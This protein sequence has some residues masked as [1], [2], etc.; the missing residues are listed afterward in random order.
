MASSGERYQRAQ[1]IVHALLE[2]PPAARPA[3]LA[4]ACGTD[5]AL[6]EEVQWLLAAAER[7]DDATLPQLQ[8]VEALRHDLGAAQVGSNAPRH[9]RLIERLGEGGM[10]QVWL[11]ERDD[12][13]VRQRVALKLL[14]TGAAP[15][16]GERARFMA[17]GRILAALNHPNIAH[18]VDAGVGDD[19]MPFLAMECVDGLALD[20]W[21]AQ[22]ELTL[23]GRIELFLKVCAAV[24]YAHA[25]LVIHRDLKP[26]NILV[27]AAGEPKLLDFG[28]ARLLDAEVGGN[29]TTVLNAMT[30]AYAS[31]EQIRGEPLGTATD[32]YSLGV[33]LYQLLTGVRPFDHLRTEHERANAIVSGQV[34]PPS[35][36]HRADGG[37]REPAAAPVPS[38]NIPADIDAIVLKALRR[39][40]EQRYTSVSELAQDLRLFLAARP[41]LARRGQWG[42]RARCFLRR[43]RWPLAMAMALAA[44]AGGFTWRTVLAE[45]EARAQARTAERVTAFLSSIF[46]ASDSNLNHSLHS[47]LTARDVLDAGT[48]RI[49][50]ELTGEPQVRAR[51][52]EAVGN[53]YRH[54]NAN[55]RA[56]GL[57]REA[58]ELNLSPAVDDRIAAARCLEALANLLA[59]GEFRASEAEDA[60][61][62]SLALAQQLTPAGSQAIANAWMVLSL[63]QNRA[64]NYRAAESSART[65]LAMNLALRDAPGQRL[66]AAYHNLCLILANRGELDEAVR[67]CELTLPVYA[68]EQQ[69]ESVGAAMTYSRSAQARARRFEVQPALAEID[70]ALRIARAAHGEQAPFAALFQLRKAVILD[71]LGHYH[72]A[73]GVLAQALAMQERINGRDSGEYAAVRLELARRQLL[74]GELDAALPVLGTLAAEFATRYGSDDPRTADAQVL[75]AQASIDAGEA[76]RAARAALD[77]ASRAW[78]GK[79]DPESPAALRVAATLAQWFALHGDGDPAQ[80]L[81]ARVLAPQA[82]S[83]VWARTRAALARA[84]LARLQGQP[85]AAAAALGAAYQRLHDQ[86]GAAHPVTARIGL[87]YAQALDAARQ[88]TL[89]APL[90]EQLQAIVARAYPAASRWRTTTP[91]H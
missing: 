51:L 66:N 18:L 11:A 74:L 55:N 71:D 58:A 31:P 4:D 85:A 8:G 29:A 40:P 72:E 77:A 70:H 27:T 80:A 14:R 59:N 81:I 1:A 64:G 21:C 63:A 56:A 52:L 88:P 30:R 15:A 57:M 91:S 47:E 73:A 28:I 6:R 19:G 7:D 49:Q 22:R 36:S 53:A 38:R 5:A 60:A 43:N 87:L 78:A 90:R 83:D 41:V 67:N 17:E 86:A 61:R 24:E 54:M 62:R 34:T 25:R 89:A 12:G 44:V 35:R 20:R 9:Y 68:A 32:I 2:L 46:A 76:T 50:R 23:R 39:E 45:R 26:A 3:Q 82:R 33:I 16:A 48:E 10:G 84:T 79:D 69:L 37:T 65:T 13:S 42:Y 75:F